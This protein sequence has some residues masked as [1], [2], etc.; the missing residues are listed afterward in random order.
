MYILK[1]LHYLAG[2]LA[3]LLQSPLYPI[4][5]MICCQHLPFPSCPHSCILLSPFALAVTYS[6]TIF[7][8]ISP[9]AKLA[10]ASCTL[11]EAVLEYHRRSTTKGL[12]DFLVSF[13]GDFVGRG[14]TN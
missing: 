3:I 4:S 1:S 8:L 5:N 6:S 11:P 10:R 2:S 13:C 12:L 9:P 14:I 7:S